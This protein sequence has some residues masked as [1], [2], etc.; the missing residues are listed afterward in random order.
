MEYLSLLNAGDG[1]YL[2]LF[3]VSVIAGIVDAI[4]GGGGLMTV[5]ALL[6]AGLPP[7][8]VL[9][10]N[11]LQAVV[12]E[13][14]TSVIFLSSQPLPQKGLITGLVCASAGAL[15]GSFAVS[16]IDKEALEVL[17]PVLMCAITLYSVMSKQLKSVTEAPAKMSSSRFMVLCGVS[18]GFYNGFFG[19]G[20][21]SL[22]MIAFVI[23]LGYTLRQASMMTKPLN[24]AGNVISLILFIVLGHVDY[25]LGMVMGIGQIIG[26]LA[27][28]RFVIS[29]G[30]RI[31]RPV[32]ISVTV[33][34]TAKLIY[35]HLWQT[36]LV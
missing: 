5:P 27:G 6:L 18:I 20:T 8:V 24:L 28:S 33:L 30:H 10:T 26:S 23:L 11:R 3:V 34:M 36:A 2:F 31:V 29:H 9:G 12:G 4:A 15:A 35:E 22:W 32:F 25:T 1:I 7:M 13:L 21:G 17:L 19:P 14:T 16:L